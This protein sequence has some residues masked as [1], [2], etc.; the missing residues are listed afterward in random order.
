MRVALAAALTLFAT[1]PAGADPAGRTIEIVRPASKGAMNSVPAIITLRDVPK[2]TACRE[3]VRAPENRTL[4]GG[5]TTV[6]LGGDRVV[7]PL[8]P[9]GTI[10]AF[11]PRAMRPAGFTPDAATWDAT[12]LTPRKTTSGPLTLVP[13]AKGTAFLGGWRLVETA[14]TKRGLRP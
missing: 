13:K 8:V 11:T 5:K 6:L 2:G 12:R 3:V 9:D 4:T 14:G 10:E 7:C 1:G